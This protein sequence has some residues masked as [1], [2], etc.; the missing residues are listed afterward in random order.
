MAEISHRKM[1]SL[2]HMYLSLPGELQLAVLLHLDKESISALRQTSRAFYNVTQVHQTP[3]VRH[4]IGSYKLCA[5]HQNFVS[6]LFPGPVSF[7]HYRQI[8]HRDKVL[9][10]LASLLADIVEFQNLKRVTSPQQ[11]KTTPRGVRAEHFYLILKHILY[12]LEN[13]PHYPTSIMTSDINH[14]SGARKGKAVHCCSNPCRHE[15]VLMLWFFDYN[16]GKRLR[17][18]AGNGPLMQNARTYALSEFKRFLKKVA[19]NI[20][21]DGLATLRKKWPVS[22]AGSLHAPRPDVQTQDHAQNILTTDRLPMVDH[23]ILSHAP[24]YVT[25]GMIEYLTY[26]R[27]TEGSLLGTEGKTYAE[28]RDNPNTRRLVDTLVS[29]IIRYGS[30]SGYALNRMLKQFI[31]Q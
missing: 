29:Y 28:F 16:V 2:A 10:T 3:V 14:A 13:Y 27:Q 9:Q 20:D 18:R 6:R 23:C 15:M 24:A 8:H 19:I 11:N 21:R 12:F 1:S 4:L 7:E 30:C 5:H 31:A 25:E 22:P 17:T 26:H